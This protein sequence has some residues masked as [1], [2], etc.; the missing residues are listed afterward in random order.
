MHYYYL[1]TRRCEDNYVQNRYVF[2]DALNNLMSL[3]DVMLVGSAFHVDRAECLN[4][5]APVLPGA[6]S[7]KQD[8]LRV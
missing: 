7:V 6:S 8:F 1:F 2:S 5:F 4:A 3:R